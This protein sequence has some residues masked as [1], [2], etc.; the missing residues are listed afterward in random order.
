MK[1]FF[2][3]FSSVIIILLSQ[4][5]LFPQNGYCWD[6]NIKSKVQDEIEKNP[7]LKEEH[8]RL[9]VEDEKNGYVTIELE[10]GNNQLLNLIHQG[11]PLSQLAS[12]G[13]ETG[14]SI[15]VM[16]LTVE[17]LARI[18]GVKAIKL[19]AKSPEVRARTLMLQAWKEKDST[20]Q[21]KMINSALK[22]APNDRSTLALASNI[23]YT[24][25]DIENA[26]KYSHYVIM[27]FDQHYDA[28]LLLA[29][30]YTDQNNPKAA[31]D[32]IN[33]SIQNSI[34]TF[35]S[36]RHINAK[37]TNVTFE[38]RFFEELKKPKF[39]KIRNEP[40]F[41]NITLQL[42]RENPLSQINH[43]NKQ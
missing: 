33:A 27:N 10:E 2:I 31:C 14:K 11:I 21:L 32:Q 12:D 28:N 41:Q 30:I 9:K 39:D 16:K 24:R 13:S 8:L 19:I 29:V 1:A 38:T 35:G 20:R 18:E 15:E 42:E 23:Y 43:L 22:I 17:T 25:K 4:I 34:K 3:N 40:C 36:G 5:L 26:V 7:F 37:G 6:F